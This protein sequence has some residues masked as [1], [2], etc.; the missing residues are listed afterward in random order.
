MRAGRD[1][2]IFVPGDKGTGPHGA[3]MRVG[4]DGLAAPMVALM[5]TLIAVKGLRKLCVRRPWLHR[6]VQQVACVGGM[7]LASPRE[8]PYDPSSNIA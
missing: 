2:R 3:V 4:F 7:H 6:T 1:R 5:V 8:K